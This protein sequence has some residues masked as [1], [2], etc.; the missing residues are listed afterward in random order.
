[1]G[2]GS[3]FSST[4]PSHRPSARIASSPSQVLRSAFHCWVDCVLRLIVFSS[5]RA[6]R[7]DTFQMPRGCVLARLAAAAKQDSTLQTA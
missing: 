6:S 5:P 7:K 3:H 1:M 4:T 2:A